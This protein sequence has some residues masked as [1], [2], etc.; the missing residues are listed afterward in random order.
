MD[1]HLYTYEGP[2]RSFDDIRANRWKGETYAVSE[3]KARVNLIYQYKREH[4]LS[5]NTKITLPGKI[6][7]VK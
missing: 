7:L 6:K 1:T 4:G 3:G 2:V 5:M